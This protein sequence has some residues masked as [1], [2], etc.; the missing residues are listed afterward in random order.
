LSFEKQTHHTQQNHD[1]ILF[2]F[3]N[4][5]GVLAALLSP[6]LGPEITS[7]HQ[8]WASVIL[9][10]FLLLADGGK[11]PRFKIGNDAVYSQGTSIKAG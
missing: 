2:V 3:P 9:S 7:H 8:N 6:T 10:A 4:F 1:H 5:T 11:Y